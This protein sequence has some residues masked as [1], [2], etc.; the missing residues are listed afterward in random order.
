MKISYFGHFHLNF[1]IEKVSAMADAA[2][3]KAS[4]SIGG[5]DPVEQKKNTHFFLT[6]GIFT[7]LAAA[8]LANGTNREKIGGTFLHSALRPSAVPR[9]PVQASP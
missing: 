9:A 1:S 6:N 2:S 3:S 7:T 5:T 4:E 8:T